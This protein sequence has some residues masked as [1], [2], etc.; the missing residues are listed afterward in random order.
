MK[1][2]EKEALIDKL[3]QVTGYSILALVALFFVHNGLIGLQ[4]VRTTYDFVC[5][6][7]MVTGI[8]TIIVGALMF[9]KKDWRKL[10][11]KIIIPF[12]A[13]TIAGYTIRY[14]GLQG[15]YGLCIAIAL[16]ILAMIGYTIYRFNVTVSIKK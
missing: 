1:K 16:F 15:I 13:V 12:L 5:V 14:F 2:R 9:V 11:T 7:A 6:L 4:T 3:F 8:G 10:L